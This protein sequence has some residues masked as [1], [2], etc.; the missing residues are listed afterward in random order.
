MYIS[1]LQ[2][3]NFRNY[4]SLELSLDKKICLFIGENGQGKTNILEA[5]TLLSTGRSHRT[6]KDRNMIRINEEFARVRAESIQR[7]GTHSVDLMLSSSEKKRIAVN[8]IAINRIGEMIGQIKSVMFSPEDLNI[9]KEGPG[10]RRRFMDMDLS[11]MNRIYF[12]SLNKYYQVLEQRNNLLKGIAFNGKNIDTL[13]IWDEMLAQAAKPIIQQRTEFIEKLSPICRRIHEHISGGK[14]QLSVI[15]QP[16]VKCDE[17]EESLKKTRE[18]DL[19]K[20]ITS[21]GPHKDD[22]CIQLDEV[23][24]RYFGS[25]GQ[26]RTAALALKL[27]QL[28]LMKAEIGE[29]PVLLLDDVMSELDEKR[30]EQLLEYIRDVQT[31]LTTTHI[32]DKMKNILNVNV[33]MVKDGQVERVK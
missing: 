32:S 10:N 3:K 12:Y 16:S 1:L 8:G 6:N 14:E 4:E 7:D 29:N 5:V 27:A 15:Y 17:I 11:Q 28:E 25:Q 33:F 23:D 31:F 9:V 18:S 30:Q 24:L 2:F 26:Q 20:T 21:I 13:E 22:L 19:K